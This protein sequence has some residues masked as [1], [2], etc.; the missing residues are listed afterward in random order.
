M[1]NLPRNHHRPYP[2][3]FI[4]TLALVIT[5]LIA[6]FVSNWFNENLK[7]QP[8]STE[9]YATAIQQSVEEKAVLACDIGADCPA[10][11]Q[12]TMIDNS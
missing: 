1:P 6:A 2:L 11:G 12:G 8:L 4:L 10:L 7:S 3:A 5:V 9:D